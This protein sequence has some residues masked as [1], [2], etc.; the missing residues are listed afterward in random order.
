MSIE[1][2]ARDLM[3]A[4][5]QK[6]QPAAYDTTA[7]VTRVEGDTLWVHIP[8]GVEET[9]VKRTISAAA[10]DEIQIRVGGGQAWAVG[11]ATVPP[12]G[13][14]KA[15]EALEEVE[16]IER[17]KVGWAEIDEAIVNLLTAGVFTV[18]DANDNVVFY[19]N[20]DEGVASICGWH[21]LSNGFMY[22]EPGTNEV[23]SFSKDGITFGETYRI[24]PSVI[25]GYTILG[26]IGFLPNIIPPRG[27]TDCLCYIQS[28]GTG[29]NARAELYLNGVNVG[30]A[31][32][33]SGWETL[34]PL[35]S[36][37]E[38]YTSDSPVQYR[39]VGK[40]VEV[41]G[42]V[43]PKNGFAAGDTATIGTLPSGYCPDETRHFICQGSLQNKWLLMIG[44]TGTMTFARYGGD[45]AQAAGT[46]AWLPFNAVF[47][48]G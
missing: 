19:A 6:P 5:A 28:V 38:L 36:D 10:G 32:A 2:T 37:F 8:G 7:T 27:I 16:R 20:A 17:L 44:S 42:V 48:A 3:S 39:K 15:L 14:G 41:R 47:L 23:W 35:G 4:L 33:D 24:M 13:D 45:T 22:T 9:P 29:A 31:I 21:V 12:T 43:K 40:M 18:K 1:K 46:S 25:N 30:G 26:K 11:N 34:T